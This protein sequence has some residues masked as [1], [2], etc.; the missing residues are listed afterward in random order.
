M[1]GTESMKKIRLVILGEKKQAVT[2][3]LHKMGI[4]DFRKSDLDLADDL[5]PANFTEISDLIIKFEGVVNILPKM[6]VEVREHVPL[7]KLLKAAKESAVLDRVYALDSERKEI[8]EDQHLLDHAHHVAVMLN[9]YDMDFGKLK[10][11]AFA[12]KAFEIDPMLLDKLRKEIRA[13]NVQAEL[14]QQPRGAK[15]SAVLLAYDKNSRIDEVLKDFKIKELDLGAK[16]LEGRPEQALAKIEAS[17]EKNA[18]KLDAIEKELRAISEKRYSELSNTLTM[19]RAELD[20]AN[21]SS[22]FKRTQRTVVIEGWIPAERQGELKSRMAAVTDGA[23]IIE[24]MKDKET[25]PTR[26]KRPKFLKPFDY[27]MEFFSIPRSDEIDPTWIFILSFPIF[28]G[29]M[30]TDVGYGLLSF[31][32]ASWVTRITDPDGLVWNAAQIWKIGAVSTII[33]GFLTN[34]YFGLALNQYFLPFSGFDIMKNVPYFV[35]LSVAFGL[36]QLSFGLLLGFINTWKEGHKLLAISKLTSISMLISGTIFVAGFFFHAAG[37]NLTTIAG[38]IG[39]VSMIATMAMSGE[40]AVEVTALIA[41]PLSYLRIVGFSLASV[42]LAML[43]DKAFT[44][45][46]DHGIVTFVLY[47]AIFL[48]LHTLNMIV[49]IFEGIVQG[50]RLNFVEFYTKFYKGGGTKFTP[51]GYK[52]AVYTKK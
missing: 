6:P 1:L 27:M 14:E 33:F 49:S 21:A 48:T 25:A 23:Y 10:S 4:I 51:F 11:E 52:K 44:P 2:E 34:Q 22:M 5:P 31:L 38:I 46:L 15:L 3:E 37:A 24:E 20:M 17:K 16:Y 42:V 39:A 19:L 41:H 28:Y 47:A 40:E 13:K 35:I 12:F 43:I 29:L 18:K 32:L 50:I 36:V 26:V 9:G 7:E 8:G 30:V 45:S